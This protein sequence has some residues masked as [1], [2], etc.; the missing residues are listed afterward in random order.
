MKNKTYRTNIF[1]ITLMGLI[2][3]A[4]SP[5]LWSQEINGG[6][7]A[8]PD[9]YK[10]LAEN[11]MM[12]VVLATWEPG[13]RDNWHGHPATAVYYVTDCH[14]RAFFPDGSSRDIQRIG[15]TGRARSRP[16]TSHSIQ[17]IGSEQCRILLVEVLTEN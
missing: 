17:N 4:F 7:E 3:V 12:R 8:S 1:L 9:I 15:G 6:H 14:V 13:A 5:R 16:V 11:E 2:L 10:V